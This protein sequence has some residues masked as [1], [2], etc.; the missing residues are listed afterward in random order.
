MG[1]SRKYYKNPINKGFYCEDR[2]FFKF[3]RISSYV[4]TIY[5]K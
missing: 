3:N 1:L 5:T 4:E 2:K